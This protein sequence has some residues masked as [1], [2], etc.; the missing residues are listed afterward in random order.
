MPS[1]SAPLTWKVVY[2]GP[3]ASGKTTNL[4]VLERRTPK[5]A[6]GEL[7][8]IAAQGP[9]EGCTFEFMTLDLRRLDC[10]PARLQVF[11]VP[12]C[13]TCAATRALVLQ[14]VDGVVFVA[15]SDATRFTANRQA[16]V[17]LIAAL[18]TQGRDPASVPIVVQLNKRELSNCAS[19]EAMRVA[20]RPL[21]PRGIIHAVSVLGEGVLPT[22]RE[23]TRELLARSAGPSAP[24]A[25]VQ[26]A[27]PAP[28]EP[29]AERKAT[30]RRAR[31]HS[32]R[33]PVLA[34]AR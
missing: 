18:R 33:Q 9:H 22:V 2:W 3:S 10:A 34:A 28:P 26:V 1:V 30:P 16:A 27:L 32:G 24:V 5:G 8:T 20:L 31:D 12:G 29:V 6:H 21:G 11:S 17:D 23:L 4:Q 25:P 14:R 13:A 15:D 19:P 7:T